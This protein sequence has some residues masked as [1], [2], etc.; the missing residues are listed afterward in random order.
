MKLK[1]EIGIEQECF[2]LDKKGQIVEPKLYGF[3]FDEYGFLV[4][5]RTQPHTNEKSLMTELIKLTNAHRAQ[6]EELGFKLHFVHRMK[7]SSDFVKR[8]A[9]KYAWDCLKDK[10]ANVY[11]GTEVSHA[12]G[13]DRWSEDR[14]IWGTA[15]THIHFSRKRIIQQETRRV[16]LP[17]R[18]I[19]MIFDARFDRI[20]SLAN[21]IAGEYEI[22]PYGFEYRSL[23]ASMNIFMA[24]HFGFILLERDRKGLEI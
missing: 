24:V 8:L 5:I 23:P 9:V 4:E 3:P 20:I 7:L 10:T 1:D 12:T 14:I 18:K 11:Y 6:A 13:V 19:V 15:G 16:Q 17:I 21:R 2:L 22:K